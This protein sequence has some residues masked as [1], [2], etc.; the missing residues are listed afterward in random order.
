VR[1]S[2]SIIILAGVLLFPACGSDGPTSPRTGT[3]RVELTDDPTDQLEEIN[4][5]ITGLTVK[6][7][8]NPVERITDEIGLIDLLSL[9]DTT[10][11]LAAVGVEPGTY[12]FI[13]V[14]LDQERSDVVEIG[15]GHKPLK[16]ASEEIKVLGGFEVREGG[17]TTVT[18]DFDAEASI[19]Q[20]GN[21]DW[22]LVPVIVQANV[23]NS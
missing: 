8:Q 14:D 5:F 18:L 10:Q 15:E 6:H 16:I 9:Q 4:V 11:L 12:Q 17:T 7:A 2:S 23:D 13:Q 22:L 1:L 19:R 3:L 21:G 20:Q